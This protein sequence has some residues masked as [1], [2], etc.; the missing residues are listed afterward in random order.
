MRAYFRRLGKSQVWPGKASIAV[1]MVVLLFGCSQTVPVQP[2]VPT[3]NDGPIEPAEVALSNPKTR[4]DESGIFLFE[5][6]YEFTKGRARQHYLVTVHFP[7]TKNLCLKHMEAWELK[8]QSGIIK[9]GI[10]LIEQP[11]QSYEITFSEADSPMNEY[12]RISNVLTGKLDGDS[13]AKKSD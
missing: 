7:G 4:I 11:I 5:F 2:L 12:K 10:P 9:D 3:V 13:A 6:K 8:S 1:G